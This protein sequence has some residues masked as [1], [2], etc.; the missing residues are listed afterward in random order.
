MQRS[1]LD[2]FVSLLEAAV[3]RLRVG[4]PLDDATEMGPLISADQRAT[5]SSY[6]DDS[7][8]VAVRGDA[9]SGFRV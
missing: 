3:K 6:V 7:S 1:A 2:R 9:P 4:D 5:V 8:P